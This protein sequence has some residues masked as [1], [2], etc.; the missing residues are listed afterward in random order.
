M[1]L[2][3][4]K[5]AKISIFVQCNRKIGV[6]FQLLLNNFFWVA[7]KCWAHKSRESATIKYPDKINF[8]FCLPLYIKI[9][10]V[11]KA[12]NCCRRLSLYKVQHNSIHIFS[13][14][15]ALCLEL[16]WMENIIEEKGREK[17]CGKLV[18]KIINYKWWYS[19]K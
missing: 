17:C 19:I 18:I 10:G 8:L 16:Y 11:G 3:A 9:Y 14:Q 4:E 15:S 1:K 2:K 13:F 12:E 6:F 7:K 5:N